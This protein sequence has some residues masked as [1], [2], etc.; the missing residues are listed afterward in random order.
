MLD[1]TV[2]VYRT[3]GRSMDQIRCYTDKPFDEVEFLES[4]RRNVPKALSNMAAR[5]VLDA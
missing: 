1:Y 5:A 4:Y 3:D 2:N